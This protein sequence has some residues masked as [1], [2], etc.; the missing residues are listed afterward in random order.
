MNKDH[1][2]GRLTLETGTRK[3]SVFVT[4]QSRCLYLSDFFADHEKRQGFFTEL[5][6]IEDIAERVFRH[7]VKLTVCAC[8]GI[9]III[10]SD[11]IE[12]RLYS[13]G[14][15]L[16]DQVLPADALKSAR[17]IFRLEIFADVTVIEYFL[18]QHIPL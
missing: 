4:F 8:L 17:D 5:G 13:A 9:I 6:F 11:L 15:V 7:G 10:L 16:P 3:E 18:V 2:L 12:G 14:S 1:I